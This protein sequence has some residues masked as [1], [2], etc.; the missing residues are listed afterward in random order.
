M[1]VPFSSEAFLSLPLHLCLPLQVGSHHTELP[2]ILQALPSW[3]AAHRQQQENTAHFSISLPMQGTNC[4]TFHTWGLLKGSGWSQTS[5]ENTIC[6]A[7]SAI[8]SWFPHSLKGFSWEHSLS[9]N[10]SLVPGPL[11][12]NLLLEV[13]SKTITKFLLLWHL[14]FHLV[15]RLSSA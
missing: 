2:R 6:L 5:L 15:V 12:Q 1:K 11:S 7:S 4:D 8:L 14:L 10:K 13:Q 3:Q 9:L